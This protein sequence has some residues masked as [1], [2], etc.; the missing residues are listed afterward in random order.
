MAKKKPK[1]YQEADGWAFRLRRGD[2]DVYQ[3]GFKSQAKAQKA[4]GE[5]IAELEGSDKPALMGPFKTSVAVGL[6]DYARERLPYLPAR[7]GSI[8]RESFLSRP[9]FL[10][11]GEFGH[12]RVGWDRRRFPWAR[13]PGRGA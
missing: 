6:M 10:A 9:R 12:P 7:R 11:L 2:I 13:V 3:S 5:L 8:G 1:P 4:L